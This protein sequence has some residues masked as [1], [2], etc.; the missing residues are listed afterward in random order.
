MSLQQTLSLLSLLCIHQPCLVTAPNNGYFFASVFTTLPA[1][2]SFADVNCSWMV[3]RLHFCWLV[4]TK[5]LPPTVSRPVCLGVRHPYGA[6]NQFFISV[7]FRES[8]V[9][10]DR[11]PILEFTSA[12]FLGW[13]SLRS[14][15]SVSA[16]KYFAQLLFSNG[17]YNH[18]KI[19][20]YFPAECKPGFPLAVLITV[21]ECRGS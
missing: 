1:C 15:L 8:R 19:K 16:E 10:W 11:A 21:M 3:C 14:C 17:P 20:K 13:D 12:V 7:T 2:D 9:Y 4:I 6:H 5:K 18:I